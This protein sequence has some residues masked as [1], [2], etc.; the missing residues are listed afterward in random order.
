M[1]DHVAN[2]VRQLSRLVMDVAAQRGLTSGRKMEW[3]SDKRSSP[4]EEALS[5]PVRT[6]G[7]RGGGQG[8]PQTAVSRPPFSAHTRPRYRAAGRGGAGRAGPAPGRCCRRR[9]PPRPAETRGAARPAGTPPQSRR[10]WHAAPHTHTL[11][12]RLRGLPRFGVSPKRS[13]PPRRAAAGRG[14]TQI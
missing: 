8:G 13:S 9:D 7:S 6:E 3:P 1:R 2:G 11:R 5:P 4:L 14:D 10:L 12:G